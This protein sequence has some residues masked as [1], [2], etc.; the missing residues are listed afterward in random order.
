MSAKVGARESESGESG[1]EG[2]AE[3]G[4]GAEAVAAGTVADL[5]LLSPAL[6]SSIS[7][8]AS[9]SGRRRLV[10]GD[11]RSY[12]RVRTSGAEAPFVLRFLRRG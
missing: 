7:Q 12:G 4:L 6:A 3:M 5:G 11:N 2:G 8:A 1:A 10:L 9:H